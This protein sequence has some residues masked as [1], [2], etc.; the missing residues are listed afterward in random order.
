MGRAAGL[1]AELTGLVLVVV[2]VPPAD[3]TA[4]TVLA[5][6]LSGMRRACL[7]DAMT[8]APTAL[9]AQVTVLAQAW[10]AWLALKALLALAAL[11]QAQICQRCWAMSSVAGIRAVTSMV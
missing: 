10:P 8:L 7:E 3:V 1:V 4:A 9:A 11:A 6:L 5:V 2:L